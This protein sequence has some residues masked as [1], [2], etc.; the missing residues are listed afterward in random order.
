[1]A[2][3]AGGDVD[4]KVPMAVWADF[5]GAA[6]QVLSPVDL[7]TG[8]HGVHGGGGQ[9]E[10]VGDATEPS[11]RPGRRCRILRTVAPGSGQL[12]AEP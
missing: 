1:V 8:E 5:T 2:E 11:R 12:P 9:A 6:L 4:R 7:A 3:Q 10:L